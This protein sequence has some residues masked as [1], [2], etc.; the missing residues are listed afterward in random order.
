MPKTQTVLHGVNHR[1]DY[2]EGPPLL[3]PHDGL[4]V[5]IEP[6]EKAFTWCVYAGDEFICPC[7]FGYIDVGHAVHAARTIVRDEIPIFY[8]RKQVEPGA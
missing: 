2:P 3:T 5:R 8:N 6:Y 4:H 1:P 7:H